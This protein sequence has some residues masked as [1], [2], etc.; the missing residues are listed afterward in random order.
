VVGA[1]IAGFIA[2]VFTSIWFALRKKNK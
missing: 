1:F 2:G